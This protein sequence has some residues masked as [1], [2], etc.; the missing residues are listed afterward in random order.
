VEDTLHI[1]DRAS[2]T[3]SVTKGD[4]PLTISWLKDGRNVQPAH[5]VSITQVDQFTSI[6]V[7]EKLSPEHNGNYSCV[8]RNL[9]AEVSHTHQLV[10]NGNWACR[11]ARFNISFL[12]L[13]FVS[14]LSQF[15]LLLSPF[16]F[17]TGCRKA[18]E[19]VPSAA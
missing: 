11:V 17:K 8:V 7:I 9:A 16:P 18:C 6:L 1:G 12:S 2:L 15:L 13:M 14:L 5:M 3:C 4:L 10:V 19:L